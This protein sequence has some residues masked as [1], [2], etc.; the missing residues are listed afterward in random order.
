MNRVS[1]ALRRAGELAGDQAEGAAEQPAPDAAVD[2]AVLAREPYPIELTE[3]RRPRPAA[4]GGPAAGGAA[5]RD[6]AAAEAPKP[7]VLLD[8]ID[9]R[10]REKIVVDAGMN[11]IG[12]AHV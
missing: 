11:K 10:V 4:L 2:I 12:I 8:R 6:G 1:D 3:H 9:V 7:P 5:V